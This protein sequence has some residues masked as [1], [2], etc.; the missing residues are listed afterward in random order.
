MID[1]NSVDVDSD[2]AG[3]EWTV[4]DFQELAKLVAVVAVGQAAHAARI[5]DQLE[6]NKPAIS[7]AALNQAACDQLTITGVTQTQVAALRAHRDGFLFECITWIATRKGASNRTFQ[8]DPHT[9]ST[10]Q[11]MDGLVIELEASKQE[12]RAVTIC[13]DKC[14]GKPRNKFQAE[15][16]KT[17]MEHHSGV[18][19]SREL[20]STAIDLIKSNFP[21][22]TEA[23]R[24]AAKVMDKDYRFYRAALTVDSTMNT[25]EKRSSLFKDY[26]NLSGIQQAQRIG[27]IFVVSE[28]LRTWFQK[29]ADAVIVEIRSGE[30]ENV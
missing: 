12:I 20:I 24:A 3:L 5:L 23:T 1:S 14:T 28:D 11:G 30:V 16:M 25:A 22:E 29:L 6:P 8:K 21:N 7:I 2:V 18:K 19:R 26:N 9:S 17:F 10:S 27:A 13:E 4:S 15:V